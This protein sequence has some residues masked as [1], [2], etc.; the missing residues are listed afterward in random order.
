MPVQVDPVSKPS[1]Q[2]ARSAHQVPCE[3]WPEFGE[4][5]ALAGMRS[6]WSLPLTVN[7]R[8]TGALNLY[9]R[10][11]EHWQ[12]AGAAPARGLAR[13]ASVVLATAPR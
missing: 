5:A 11:D 9:S 10:L 8:T 12:T 2:V 6:V 1:A 4:M 13:Q 7:E 3:R